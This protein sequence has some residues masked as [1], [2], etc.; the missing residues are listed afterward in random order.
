[1]LLPK[2]QRCR[3]SV[4]SFDFKQ[5]S[6]SNQARKTRFF[7]SLYGYTQRVS[8]RLKDGQVVSYSYHY[9]GILDECPHV[10][11]GKSVFGIKP[12]DERAILEL[13]NSF[14]EVKYYNFI[15]YIRESDCQQIVDETKSTV[16]QNILKFGY[17]SILLI[18][19]L[20]DGSISRLDLNKLGYDDNY[21]DSAL[22]FLTEY[23]LVKEARGAV[24]CTKQGTLFGRVLLDTFNGIQ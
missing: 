8:R 2:Y 12:G 11:L 9:P 22:A 13:F 21:L 20:H 15:G 5:A 17:L 14:E 3:L 24:V 19:A 16:S 18:A 4:F 10:K 1:M 7:R 23:G 6:H